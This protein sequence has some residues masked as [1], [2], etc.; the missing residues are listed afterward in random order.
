MERLHSL[1]MAS[2]T[3]TRNVATQSWF[4]Q[5]RFIQPDAIFA[6]TAQYIGSI[7]EFDGE[8]A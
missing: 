8:A 7:Q 1:T 6:L 4:D 5:A 2:Q 3:I